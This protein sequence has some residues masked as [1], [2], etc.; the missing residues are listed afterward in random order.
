MP[1][2]QMLLGAGGGGAAAGVGQ[3]EFTT[4]GTYTFTVP[5]GVTSVSVVCIGSGGS[6]GAYG[7]GG[8]SLAYKN[9]ISVTWSIS[10]CYSG[11]YKPHH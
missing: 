10:Y 7:A 4:P 9:N 11:R 6:G 3:E 1:I 2:Q 5:A 8:G